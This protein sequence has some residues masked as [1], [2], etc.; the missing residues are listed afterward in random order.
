MNGGRPSLRTSL[1][2]VHPA[3]WASLATLTTVTVTLFV[4]RS[5]GMPVGAWP[6]V[7]ALMLGAYLGLALFMLKAGTRRWIPWLRAAAVIA[8][9]AVRSGSGWVVFMIAR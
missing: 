2:K 4:S 1:H 5:Q 6:G 9:G 7:H 8:S 3:D